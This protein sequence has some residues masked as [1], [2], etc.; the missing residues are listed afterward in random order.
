MPNI[1]FFGYP[2]NV[3]DGLINKVKRRFKE[4]PEEYFFADDTVFT[5]HK[6]TL[7]YNTKE[8]NKPFIRISSNS[9]RELTKTV[10]LFRELNMKFDIELM[11]LHNFVEIDPF[12]KM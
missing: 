10:K 8:E 2:E 5:V 7:V 3:A 11:L 12:K 6:Q 9:E 4:N 1:E